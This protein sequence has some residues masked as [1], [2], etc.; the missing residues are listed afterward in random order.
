MSV[1]ALIVAQAI[2]SAALPPCAVHEQERTDEKLPVLIADCGGQGFL[3]G[4]A[5]SYTVLQNPQLHATLVDIVRGNTRRVLMLSYENGRPLLE[6]ITGD[7]ALAAGRGVM[8]GI[9]GLDVDPGTFAQDGT[10]SVRP[11]ASD[12]V[13]T[14]TPATVNLGAQIA[15][16]QVRAS[17]PVPEPQAPADQ[18]PGDD[19]N[20]S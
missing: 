1:L 9:K 11:A 2:S 16:E 18:T 8:S 15:A 4:P 12:E 13:R 7:L 19:E 5:E 10:I 20:G 17:T 14:D 3:L 6:D